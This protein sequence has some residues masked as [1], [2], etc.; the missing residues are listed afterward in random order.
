MIYNKLGTT[1]IEVSKICLGTMTWGEQNTLAEAHLQC[2]YAIEHGVNFFDTAEMYPIPPQ[3]STYGQTETIIGRWDKL[4]N[5]RDQIILASKV[6]GPF[7]NDYIRGGSTKL[8]KE[9]ILKACDASLKRLGTDYIDLYQLHWPDRS[10]NCFGVKNFDLNS[11]EVRTPL[12]ETLEVLAQ[13]VKEGKIRHCG[14]S[15]ETPWGVMSYQQL[16]MMN[17]SYPQ[18]VSIQNPYSLLN[19]TFEIGLAEVAIREKIGLLAYSPLGF[20]VLSGKYLAGAK[21]KGARLTLYSD[22]TRYTKNENAIN[23]TKEYVALAKKNDLK[24]AQMALSFVNSRPFVTSN[25]IGATNLEQLAENILSID[26][27]LTDEVL[28][29]LEVIADKYSNPCP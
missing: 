6:V 28:S 21:P 22:Y 8:N 27:N 10:T 3:K 25:I 1:N 15:N 5:K 24:P 12:E 13:L 26:I 16:A 19:R 17:K 29:E 23:A 20:G 14:I 2:D 4:K 18:M 9:H 11:D 7:W